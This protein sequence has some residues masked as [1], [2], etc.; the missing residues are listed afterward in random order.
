MSEPVSRA[1]TLV[2]GNYQGGNRFFG[3]QRRSGSKSSPHYQALS[4]GIPYFTNRG[5][6]AGLQGP[7]ADFRMHRR[8]LAGPCQ[9]PQRH[10]ARS[11]ASSVCQECCN[12][13][14]EQGGASIRRN[15]APLLRLNDG[16]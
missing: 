8:K 6:I 3:R 13:E 11:A 9:R 14:T 7:R 1:V 12:C 2:S 10:N 15:I 5:R 16:L 4:A